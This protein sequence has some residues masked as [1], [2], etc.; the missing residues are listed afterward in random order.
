MTDRRG[1]ALITALWVVAALGALLTV[2][3]A[4]LVVDRQA[5][6]NRI[7]LR[8][9]QWAALACLAVVQ[10]RYRPGAESPAIDSLDLGQGAWCAT[11]DL[12]PS[13]RL[14]VNS[15]D[16][17]ALAR[18]LDP[19]LAAA[20]LDWRDGDDLPRAAGAEAEWYGAQR[21]PL[22]RN[23]PFASAAEL[24]L[25]RGFE[26][27]TLESVE[28]LL[29][30]R[31]DGRIDPNHAPSEV[32]GGLSVLPAAAVSRLARIRQGGT[33]LDDPEEVAVASGAVLGA[34][35]FRSLTRRLVFGSPEHVVRIVGGAASGPRTA[36]AT[37][38][39]TLR[40]V[41]GRLDVLWIEV[42]A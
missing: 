33:R 14:N 36:R 23:G 4:P 21:R 16:S 3:I 37:L 25:V 39:V 34:E 15:A 40:E 12:D 9:A 5:S 30:V 20:I 2:G 22:P 27:A 6:E 11:A 13:R 19:G 32:I 18:V 35:A 28:R 38:S 31:G 29:T 26:E 24:L 1:F 42:G 41:G 17:V 8:R 7:L 10:G